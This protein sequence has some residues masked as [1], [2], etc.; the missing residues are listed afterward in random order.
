MQ[1]MTALL[2]LA[3]VGL[4]GAAFYTGRLTAPDP[5]YA[6]WIYSQAAYASPLGL[7]HFQPEV[8]TKEETTRA[9]RAYAAA[10]QKD[11]NVVLVCKMQPG[12]H[13]ELLDASPYMATDGDERSR[14]CQKF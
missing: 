5:S 14:N 9:A 10:D 11:L 1:K 8:G 7:P 4:G 3:G 12:P 13:Q 2:L 6:L